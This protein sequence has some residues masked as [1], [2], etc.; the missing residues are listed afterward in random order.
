MHPVLRIADRRCAADI[1]ANVV[2]ADHVVH[3]T[4]GLNP[5]TVAVV[6]TN[7]IALYPVLLGAMIEQD[8]W[9]VAQRCRTTGIGADEVAHN[10]V[11]HSPAVI[12][13][14]AI[15][16][17][18]TDEVAFARRGA[19]NHV[20]LSTTFNT[21]AISATQ[22]LE[23][24]CVSTNMVATDDV[25][26]GPNSLNLYLGEAVAT[27]DVAL[28]F[29]RATHFVL[30][31]TSGDS[32]TGSTVAMSNGAAN[33]RTDKIA[34]HYVAF[35]IDTIYFDTIITVTGENV[36]FTGRPASH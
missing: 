24:R 8:T 20:V 3:R 16:T 9:P 4:A 30:L 29:C 36:S 22:S 28:S 13:D 32:Y 27:D 19:P 14:H 6:T 23:A 15:L 12:D 35:G 26:V 2:A 1:G 31:S 7:D 17:V 33:V 25:V 18:A 34:N 5:H 21:H 10:G 11:A